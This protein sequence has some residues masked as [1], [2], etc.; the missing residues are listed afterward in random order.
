MA[1][2]K[3]LPF[4]PLP[5]PL[6]QSILRQLCNALDYLHEKGIVHSDVKTRNILITPDGKVSL[7]DFGLAQEYRWHEEDEPPE[8]K[9][10]SFLLGGVLYDLAFGG[11][12]VMRDLQM[13]S[14]H[15]QWGTLAWFLDDEIQGLSL[16]CSGEWLSSQQ[17]IDLKDFMMGLLQYNPMDRMSMKEALKHPFLR[18]AP[19]S[20]QPQALEQ[21]TAQR[22]QPAPSGCWS[23]FWQAL[24][25]K[26]GPGV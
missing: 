16:A 13:L 6:I 1:W 26:A 10:D 3:S 17:A 5:A 8:P 18:D 25:P 19:S 11:L 14:N 24:W 20:G 4:N 9:T 23:A 2:G 7:C 22:G 12:G 21:V 15:A